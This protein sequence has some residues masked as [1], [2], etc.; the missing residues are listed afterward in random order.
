MRT[1]SSAIT[2]SLSADPRQRGELFPPSVNELVFIFFQFQVRNVQRPYGLERQ[3]ERLIG[4]TPAARLALIRAYTSQCPED[5][6]PIKSLTFAVIAVTHRRFFTLASCRRRGASI[7]PQCAIHHD[8]PEPRCFNDEAG[9]TTASDSVMITITVF[10]LI[11]GR[12]P[13]NRARPH[14]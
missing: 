13:Y 5:P 9:H 14:T 8:G 12:S 1:H 7:G 10:S 3:D 6:C 11:A 4:A 2:V